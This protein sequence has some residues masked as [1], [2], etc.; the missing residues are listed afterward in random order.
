MWLKDS[1]VP[2]IKKYLFFISIIIFLSTFSHILY[3]Y[4]YTW[5]KVVPIEWGTVTEGIIWDFPHLNPLI[6][7]SDYNKYIVNILYRS[8]LKYD[9]KE[10]KLV[11][12]IASCD[13]KDF[14]YIECFLSGNPKWSDGTPITIKDIKTTY[15]TILM[16]EVNPIIVSLLSETEIE[17]K[18]ESIIFNNKKSDVNF[19]NVL[20][21]P[22]VSQRVLNEINI[23]EI[24]E[25]FPLENALYSWYFQVDSITK[26]EA[27][28][29]SKLILKKNKSFFNNPFIL[30]KIVFNVFKDPPHFLKHIDTVNIFNDKLNLLGETIPR[31]KAFSYI[32]PQYFSLFLNVENIENKDLRTFI[33]SS[34]QRENIVKV[35][36]EKNYAII[37]NPYFLSGSLDKELKEK[38]IV[39]LMESE[40]YYR[41]SA[42]MSDF[43]KEVEE[44]QEK[45]EKTGSWTW[46]NIQED[47][48]DENTVK[49]SKQQEITEEIEEK[50]VLWEKETLNIIISPTQEKYNF[51]SEDDIL[52]TGK[53]ED[54]TVEKVYINDY[55][56]QGFSQW[57][58]FFYYRLK[59][60]W[61]SS[62]KEWENHYKIYFEKNGKKELKAEIIY[63]FYRDAEKLAQA[64]SAFLKAQEEALTEKK[65]VIKEIVDED[66]KEE[67]QEDRLSEKQKEEL[68]FLEGLDTELFY[69]K[70]GDAFTLKFV[71]L[72]TD[73]SAQG[74]IETIESSLRD[75]GILIESIPVSL[76][77]LV[78]II[79]SE[80]KNYDM[81]FA[82]IN[83][84]F[85]DNLFPY[86]HSSQIKNGYN[87]SNFKKLSLD[88][89]LEELKGSALSFEEEEEKKKKV[90]NILQQE[91]VMKTLYTP[92]LSLLVDKSIKD[93]SFPKNIKDDSL[94]I[95]A[96]KNSYISEKRIIDFEGK[97]FFGF[98]SYLFS[99]LL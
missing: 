39:Q 19:L 26:D 62:I 65:E 18:E 68:S 91:S 2:K 78:Q 47:K 53:V 8:L 58:E 6:L 84:G 37:E 44:E 43:L 48:E 57:D 55:S 51:V 99:S 4:L 31:L 98:I 59:E 33:F 82:G 56:L 34:I 73:Q 15:D 88:I 7:S 66:P 89:L 80:E 45:E 81:V 30:D 90:I 60:V 42:L 38:N 27:L 79:R 40:G 69:N 63:F 92:H 72:D 29:I 13:I 75:Y 87:F 86:F 24:K 25:K 16:T 77:N 21:Q 83:L 32:M 61:F 17:I 76:S 35:A 94:R 11:S 22:I 12:D 67:S 1:I 50:R 10:G 41:S 14:S 52:I 20:F 70:E 9:Y 95:D 28:G 36:G 3:S 93:F 23:E 5:A 54:K 46:D 96:L 71:Y 64:K 49:A 85:F 74:V 97:S